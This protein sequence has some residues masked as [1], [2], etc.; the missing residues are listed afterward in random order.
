LGAF[1]LKETSVNFCPRPTR[2]LLAAACGCLA[3]AL[4]PSAHSQTRTDA[5]QP[6]QAV[7]PAQQTAAANSAVAVK[8]QKP[9]IRWANYQNILYYEFFIDDM[10]RRWKLH[11]LGP[12]YYYI[13]TTGDPRHP[14]EADHAAA[15]RVEYPPAPMPDL[16][17]L[18]GISKAEEPAIFDICLEATNRMN[19]VG[20]EYGEAVD[21]RRQ[22]GEAPLLASD[23]AMV[24]YLNDRWAVIEEA[25]GRLQ[26]A[27]GEEDFKKLDAY[28]RPR[29][30][31]VYLRA[32]LD[33]TQDYLPPSIAEEKE[34]L[35]ILAPFGRLIYTTVV[36]FGWA[37][38]GGAPAADP[39]VVPAGDPQLN[40]IYGQL[41]HISEAQAQTMQSVLRDAYVQVREYDRQARLAYQGAW[42]HST[43]EAAAKR[44]EI[45]KQQ[46]NNYAQAYFRLR[47]ELGEEAFNNVM[48]YACHPLHIS[49]YPP[50]EEILTPTGTS[51]ASGTGQVQ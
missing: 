34:N 35:G 44:D 12:S 29:H 19:E 50:I 41:M 32:A 33:K 24:K 40:R 15:R 21:E 3:F 30:G 18:A 43:P 45:A 42:I 22:L 46:K 28:L 5:A 31:E 48:D 16:S 2:L 39:Y 20:K 36:D 4:N 13:L 8:E 51:A 10:A 23:P 17:A 1:S 25:W 27:L 6:A 7:Q 49:D 14:T 47:R 9:V 38:G 26:E 37:A 11:K